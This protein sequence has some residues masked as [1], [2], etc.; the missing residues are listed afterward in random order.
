M[1]REAAVLYARSIAEIG[2][3]SMRVFVDPVA[4][5]RSTGKERAHAE[6]AEEQRKQRTA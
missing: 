1:T 5:P 4:N 6:K 3:M 2:M